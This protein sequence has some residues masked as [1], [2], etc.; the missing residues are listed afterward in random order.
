M[1]RNRIHPVAI[2]AMAL[3]ITPA[4][5]ATSPTSKATLVTTQV[6]IDVD[7]DGRVTTVEPTT[8]L[9]QLVTDALRAR[10][11]DWT[12]EA[13]KLDGRPVAGTTYAR[14]N[15][16]AA[17]SPDAG[18]LAFAIG[19]VQNGP[20]VDARML[21]P[22][23]FPPV[24]GAMLD[25]GKFEMD[26]VYEVGVDGRASVV[27]VEM[28]PSRPA[29]RRQLES[30]FRKWLM[31]MHFEPE[32]LDGKAVV[33]RMRL[34]VTFTFEKAVSAPSKRELQRRIVDENPTCQALLRGQEDADKPQVALDSPFRLQP[35]G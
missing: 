29:I 26:A 2:A 16:C 32:R 33:T 20:G 15:I 17:Q 12:F 18:G 7:A 34:P 5:A 21:R 10:A 28:T 11:A 30:A 6:R 3:L 8:A 23:F 22:T 9:P 25:L 19:D 4:G 27:S 13:P 1:T 14:M 24:T 35:A 31:P